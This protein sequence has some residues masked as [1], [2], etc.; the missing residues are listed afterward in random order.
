MIVNLSDPRAKRALLS[1]IGALQGPHR[2]EVCKFKPRRSDRQ[3]SY[4]WPCFVEPFAKW[5]REENGDAAT[6]QEAHEILK[7]R[8]LRR[9]VIDKGTGEVLG[10]VTRSTTE[11]DTSEFTEFLDQCA[12]FLAD[13][14]GIAVPPAG[15]EVSA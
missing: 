6:E 10:D 5:L 1:R 15:E 4:Y 3:N 2:I 8:F 11:L 14:C 7:H 9:T 12:A 13:Y